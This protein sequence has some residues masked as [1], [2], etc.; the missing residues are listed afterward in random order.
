MFYKIISLFFAFIIVIVAVLYFAKPEVFD[1]GSPFYDNF[2][3][4]SALIK[5]LE[6][7][8]IAKFPKTIGRLAL[9][10]PTERG[11]GISVDSECRFSDPAIC[12]KMY[13]VQYRDYKGDT[14]FVNISKFKVN[15]N[16][17]E[18]IDYLSKFANSRDGDFLRFEKH[19]IGWV[20]FEMSSFIMV[21]KG[22]CQ[23]INNQPETCGYP[24]RIDKNDE[25]VVVYSTLFPGVSLGSVSTK[26]DTQSNKIQT[27]SE[28]PTE[29][30][31][32]EGETNFLAKTEI[33]QGKKKVVFGAQISRED[34]GN[35][36]SLIL[37]GDNDE[38]SVAHWSPTLFNEEVSHIYARAGNYT[39]SLVLVPKSSLTPDVM[40]RQTKISSL[41]NLIVIKS[42]SVTV[43][44]TGDIKIQN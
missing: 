17:T 21:Q 37:F 27:L 26:G 43:D 18:V 24:N 34:G 3:S 35:Y 14:Y 31:F 23:T 22:V 9:Y 32:A 42:I 40:N 16:E 2:Y 36:E 11:V 25:V 10:G 13:R 20:S 6:D 39:A 41:S 15:S 8:E 1:V 29:K 12:S 33:I 4:G 5:R 7:R 44:S 30:G 38:T 19:E 28:Y